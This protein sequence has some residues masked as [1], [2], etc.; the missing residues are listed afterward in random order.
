[1]FGSGGFVGTAIQ[2]LEHHLKNK[3]Y[4]LINPDVVKNSGE[5]IIK[6]DHN[7]SMSFASEV[8][9]SKNDQIEEYERLFK[10]MNA[11]IESL[12]NYSRS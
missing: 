5:V 11:P 2:S 3:K 7:N 12:V 6:G 1:M 4:S 9:M 8:N 10:I